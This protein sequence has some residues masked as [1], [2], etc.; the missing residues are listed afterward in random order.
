MG[1][2]HSQLRLD[3]GVHLI[4]IVMPRE[5]VRPPSLEDFW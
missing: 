3:T 4:T 1:E 2:H 5:V